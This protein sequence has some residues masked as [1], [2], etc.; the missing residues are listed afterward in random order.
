MIANEEEKII[1]IRYLLSKKVYNLL[2]ICCFKNPENQEY[3]MQFLDIFINHIGY[4]KFVID[5]LENMMKNTNIIK[6][7]GKLFF[8]EKGNNKQQK[9]C[10]INLMIS[11]ISKLF[12]SQK[13]YLVDFLDKLCIQGS[14][15][16]IILF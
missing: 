3:L 13:S 6:K 15:K 5:L 12:L 4:G 14:I 10:F 1:K 2:E 11:Q 9:I 7:V 16:Y 8:I